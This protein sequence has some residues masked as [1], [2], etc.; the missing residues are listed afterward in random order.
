M[1]DFLLAEFHQQKP[2]FCL[3]A[4]SLALFIIQCGQEQDDQ[5]ACC[6]G[7]SGGGDSSEYLAFKNSFSVRAVVCGQLCVSTDQNL[8]LISW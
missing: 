4:W 5:S 7:Y 8:V 3:L 1:H 6:F 2:D